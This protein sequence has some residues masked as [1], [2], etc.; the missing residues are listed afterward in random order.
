MVLLNLPTPVLLQ[1]LPENNL[2]GYFGKIFTL[3]S[4]IVDYLRGV[5]PI[6]NGAIW[7][8]ENVPLFE[9]V[10]QPSLIL[11]FGM[12]VLWLIASGVSNFFRR[13]TKLFVAGIVAIMITG[14]MGMI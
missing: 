14:Y 10:D 8:K 11:A 4:T 7:L 3:M 9:S 12:L 5:L 2:P 1:S 6:D 13:Y